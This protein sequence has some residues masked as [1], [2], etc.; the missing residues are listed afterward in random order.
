[1]WRAGNGEG[2]VGG[3]GDYIGASPELVGGAMQG[4]DSGVARGWAPSLRSNSSR[5][6]QL[7]SSAAAYPHVRDSSDATNNNALSIVPK[8]SEHRHVLYRG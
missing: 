8:Y 2:R 4:K 7:S 3:G 5:R 1:M 6:H